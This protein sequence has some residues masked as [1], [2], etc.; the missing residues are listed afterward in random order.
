MLTVLGLWTE[1]NRFFSKAWLAFMIVETCGVVITSEGSQ[2]CDAETRT[3]ANAP[4]PRLPGRDAGAEG[5]E[6]AARDLIDPCLLLVHIIRG[7]SNRRAESVG[8]E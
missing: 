4:G 8:K 6:Q 2:R 5:R 3:L 7:P 1:E